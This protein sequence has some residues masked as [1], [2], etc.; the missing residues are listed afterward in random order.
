MQELLSSSLFL[1]TYGA[2]NL[3]QI[4]KIPSDVAA[5]YNKIVTPGFKK[6]LEEKQ[7]IE[8]YCE[9]ACYLYGAVPLEQLIKIYN[10][11]EPKPISEDEFKQIAC[12]LIDTRMMIYFKD[13]YLI[14]SEFID[15]EE[16]DFYKGL[17]EDQGDC[18]YYIPKDREEF[19]NYGRFDYQE[20]DENTEKFLL[21]LLEKYKLGPNQAFMIFQS[22]QQEMRMNTPICG[23]TESMTE[24]LEES[25][26]K[27]NNFKQIKELEDQLKKMRNHTRL[28]CYRGHTPAEINSAKSSQKIIS[29]PA[30]KKVY[31]N[32]PCPCGSGKKYKHCCGRK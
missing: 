21:F 2:Y 8:L 31:P 14:S 29:F 1:C 18:T 6:Q 25:G 19:L 28:L 20:P 7:L 17:L 12:D 11:Y 32:D 16:E 3:N 26:K 9:S 15:G 4:L 10:Q 23:L 13:V 27:I 22:I 5:K 30:G 24:Y